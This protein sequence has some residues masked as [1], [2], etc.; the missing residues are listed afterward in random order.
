[1]HYYAGIDELKGIRTV[2]IDPGHGGHDTGC[3]GHKHSNEKHVAL[4]VALFLGGYIEQYLPDVKVIYTRK[5]DVFVELEER[6]AIANRNDADLFISI[7]CNAASPAAFG[8][9]T[10]VMGLHKTEGN[11]NV[12]KR[13]NS[14]MGLEDNYLE[15]YGFDFNSPE[16]YIM[17]S[18]TQNA[19]L[20]Q[21]TEFAALV[22][23]QF[24]ERVGRHDRGVKSAGFWVLWR[25]AMPSV[26]IETGFLTNPKEES[27][28]VSTQ[29]QEYMA[30][31]IFRAFREY[32]RRV[33]I[34]LNGL[35]TIE[36]AEADAAAGQP[37]G[38]V[39][40]EAMPKTTYRVQLL[41]S[42]TRYDTFSKKFRHVDDLIIEEI[43]S[44]DAALF[45]Y[46][47]G[48]YTSKEYAAEHMAELRRSGFADAFITVYDDGHRVQ[49]IKN[50][51]IQ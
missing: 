43:R 22:Q 37:D 2:V 16:S 8:A 47:A 42:S 28:L 39:D 9:E 35:D 7:H 44:G 11:L 25:T 4:K 15:R 33:D 34:R 5:T 41:V 12:A 23:E 31:A 48:P 36:P 40:H 1:M 46:S 17:L 18:L 19:F 3:I 20:A 30:S 10:F 27:F 29:G 50:N 6:A 45:R 32:K 38:K 21:S 14:V 26:L 24:R 49:I 13:E 51:E